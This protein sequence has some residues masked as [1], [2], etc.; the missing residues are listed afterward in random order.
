MLTVIH[1]LVIL[2]GVLLASMGLAAVVSTPVWSPF[3]IIRIVYDGATLVFP[4]AL[5]LSVALLATRRVGRRDVAVAFGGAAALLAAR[6]YATHFEP[7][8]VQI[9]EI[10]ITTPKVKRE[11]RVLHLSDIQAAEVGDYERQVFR[12]AAELRPDLV[13]HTGDLVQP[14]DRSRFGVEWKKL[15]VLFERLPAPLGRVGVVGDTDGPLVAALKDG[16][17]SLRTLEN[18]VIELE[19]G[20]GSR[21]RI[22]GLGLRVARNPL[23]SRRMIEPFVHERPDALNFVIA[24]PPDFILQSTDLPIDL[25]LAGH[26]HGGQ[27]RIPFFGPIVTLSAVPRDW[28]LGYREVGATRLNVSAGIGAEHRAG[29]ASIRVNCPP[30]VILIRFVPG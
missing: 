5:L 23:A 11:L 12:V 26:T 30:E 22:L 2:G 9:R 1:R 29:L 17:S 13:I 7:S 15:S 4:G 3:W 18:E 20:E 27:I 16:G 8:R 21:V 24:H 28:A 14:E 10:I 19:A 6:G 25:N